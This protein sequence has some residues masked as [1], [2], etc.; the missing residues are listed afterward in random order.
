M[1]FI[2]SENLKHAQ[3]LAKTLGLSSW[4]LLSSIEQLRG[5]KGW[6]VLR[7]QYNTKQYN[8][9]RSE[10]MMDALAALG[11]EVLDVNDDWMRR[12]YRG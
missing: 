10:Q 1:V 2:L 3:Y 12:R 4:N 7:W 5:H 9:N 6:V 11:A 8:T